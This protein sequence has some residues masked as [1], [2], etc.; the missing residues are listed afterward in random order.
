MNN[1]SFSPMGCY[2]HQAEFLSPHCGTCFQSRTPPVH[3]RLRENDLTRSHKTANSRPET[4]YLEPDSRRISLSIADLCS[5]VLTN[6]SNSE[7]EVGHSPLL[8][9][10]NASRTDLSVPSFGFKKSVLP[11]AHSGAMAV[12]VSNTSST[13][14]FCVMITSPPRCR[15]LIVEAGAI[16]HRCRTASSPGQSKCCCN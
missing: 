7:A 13:G 14:V 12:R 16:S 5:G 8:A 2:L 11:I 6:G 4:A 3:P 15:F 10:L 1:V 9:V